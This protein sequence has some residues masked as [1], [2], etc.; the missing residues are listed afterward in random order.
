VL[1]DGH[2]TIDNLEQV[3]QLSVLYEGHWSLEPFASSVGSSATLTD[4]L[5]ASLAYIAA[6]SDQRAL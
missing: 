3:R 1:V 4:D 5:R 6:G 2:D